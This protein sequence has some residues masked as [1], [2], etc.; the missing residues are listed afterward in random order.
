MMGVDITLPWERIRKFCAKSLAAVVPQG[1]GSP[2]GEAGSRE[3]GDRSSLGVDPTAGPSTG[4]KQILVSNTKSGSSGRSAIGNGDVAHAFDRHVGQVVVR[5]RNP[6]SGGDDGVAPGCAVTCEHPE[7]LSP[8]GQLDA[9]RDRG[10]SAEWSRQ[11]RPTDGRGLDKLDQPM[12]AVSASSTKRWARS[13]RARPTDGR[14][15]DKLD[16][17]MGAVSTSSTSRTVQLPRTG[18]PEKSGALV[19]APTLAVSV[20]NWPEKA[21]SPQLGP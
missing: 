5:Y 12:G 4:R 21:T 7:I 10:G 19:A 14:G 6:T 2:A 8:T 3:F 20:D 16:Q 17:P 11:A 18:P 9:I 15:L 1:L 13:R